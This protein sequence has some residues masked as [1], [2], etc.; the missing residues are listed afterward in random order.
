MNLVEAKNPSEPEFHQAVREVAE[1]LASRL[2]H[3][4]HLVDVVADPLLDD[5][6]GEGCEDRAEVVDVGV[7]VDSSFG[8][9][10]SSGVLSCGSACQ[11]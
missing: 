3:V 1:S 11:R 9:R 6:D 10:R 5:L 2:G 4:L 8:H 7:N